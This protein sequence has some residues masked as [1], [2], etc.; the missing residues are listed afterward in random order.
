MNEAGKASWSLG[1]GMEAVLGIGLGPGS[2]RVQAIEPLGSN[3]FA[4]RW[5]RTSVDSVYQF[6]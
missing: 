5:E 2:G 1:M 4:G 6:P 3:S